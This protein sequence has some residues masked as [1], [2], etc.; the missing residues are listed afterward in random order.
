MSKEAIVDTV[1]SFYPDV[2]AIYLF[3]TYLTQDEHKGSDVDIAVLF[4]P[5]KAKTL[6]NLA[7]TE[8]SRL[9]EDVL[10]RTVD[11][12]NIRLVNTV[13]QAE[14]I[15]EGRLIY[16]QNEYVVDEFEMNVTS[17]YQKLQEERADIL[18]DIMETGRI[19]R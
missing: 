11:L 7:L 4:S 17:A 2:E 18:K 6:R 9:L 15:R 19:L 10:K 8:C 16:S 13:F 1:L 3:G 14:I 5:S 12:I